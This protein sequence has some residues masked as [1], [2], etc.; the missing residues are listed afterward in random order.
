MQRR[1]VSKKSF[2]EFS[3]V[4]IPYTDI[5]IPACADK[6]LSI[7]T[8]DNTQD[9]VGMPGEGV[10]KSSCVDIPETNRPVPTPTRQH[11]AIRSE[12]DTPDNICVSFKRC[13]ELSSC[14]YG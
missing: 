3:V 1:G 12:G 5:P 8:E 14:C 2:S 9:V 11:H 4:W 6:C 10:Q 13:F 7:W